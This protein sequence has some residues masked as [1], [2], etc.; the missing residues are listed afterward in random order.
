[1][2]EQGGDDGGGA[3]GHDHENN[4]L[5]DAAGGASDMFGGLADAAEAADDLGKKPDEGGDGSDGSSDSSSEQHDPAVDALRSGEHAAEAVKQTTEA[6]EHLK[7]GIEGFEH[8]D[9]GEGAAGLGDGLG[10][11][12]DVIGS[13]TEAISAV[14]PDE[15]AR[16]IVEDIGKVAEGVGRVARG[17]GHLV[18][19]AEHIVEQ[20]VNPRQEVEFHLTIT[21]NDDVEF[22]VRHVHF[23]DGIGRLT[24]TV[25]EARYELEHHIDELDLLDKDVHLTMER[26]EAQRSIRGIIREAEITRLN[27]EHRVRV[28]VVPALWLLSQGQDSRIYQQEKVPDLVVKVVKEF[29]QQRFR[30]VRMELT[31][32]Y[33]PHEYLVQHR[34]SHYEFISRLLDEEGI[35]FYFDH[36]DAD[37]HHEVLVLADSND[38][39][40]H[41]EGPHDGQIEWEDNEERTQGH[42]CAFG[43][44][45]TERIGPTDATVRGRDWTN[46][47]L[48]VEHGRTGRGTWNTHPLEVYDHDHPVRHDEYDEGARHYRAHDAERRS[49]MHSERLDIARR[50]WTVRDHRRDG[51]PGPHLRA[52]ELGGRRRPIFD[53]LGHRERDHRRARRRDPRTRSRSS[54][55][56]SP[57][58]RR[59]PARR[60]MPGPE[61]ATVTGDQGEE[62]HTDQHGRIKVQFHWDRHGQTRRALDRWIRVAQGW[63]G[64]SWGMMFIPRVGMEVI[65]SFLGGDPDRPV[66]TGCLYNGE[67]PPPYPLPDEKTKSTIKTEQLTRRRRLERAPLRGQGRQRGGLHPRPEGLQRGRR[68][69]PHDPRQARPDEHGRRRSDR[70]RR[71]RPDAARQK[72]PHQDRRRRR[73]EHDQRRPRHDSRPG[74]WRRHPHRQE[75]PQGGRRGSER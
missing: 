43:F 19:G 30:D 50:S 4:D 47:A 53:R 49:R 52:R 29:L 71:S 56:T 40:P 66:V 72:R 24:T 31:Q 3:G 70:D 73:E 45:R 17:L 37:A 69:R 58:G 57:T 6:A 23:D 15:G 22:H 55:S 16:R 75:E 12:G 26:G 36:D 38:N 11:G 34:E 67:N 27:E 42:D 32:E 28:E 1:M 51:G 46:P 7:K 20:M 13:A 25:I 21:G 48:N 59:R 68:A 35:F 9:V 33:Q 2:S 39:R 74:R 41:I 8:G 60:L 64:P 18:E 61:T 10:D 14:I 63:A 54:P 44:H 62:I 65:V 5:G